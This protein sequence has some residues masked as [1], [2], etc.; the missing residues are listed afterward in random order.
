MRNVRTYGKA[1]YS[2]AV[3]HGGPGAP[4]EM[5][6]VA[7][8]LSAT[9]GV[10]EPI[11]TG[12][13]VEE[14]VEELKD[15]LKDSAVLPVTLIG[16]SWGAMLS[17][18]FAARNPSFMKKLI[19][20]GSG[21]FEDRYAVNI[22]KTRTGR[23]S[24]EERTRLNYLSEALNDPANLEKNADFARLGELLSKADSYDPLF[25]KSEAI[26][27]QYDIYESVWKE[28][29]Q[30]RTSGDLLRMGSRIRCPV[31]AIHGDYDPHSAE[32]VEIPLSGVLNDFRFILLERCGHRPWYERH[33]K[34]RFY[35]ILKSELKTW[36]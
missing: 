5:A 27:C 16:F 26:E 28:A 34:E 31:V 19:L 9:Y 1:P 29:E 18:V 23:L 24:E 4:G 11:Q 33:A 35:A 30:V 13:T 10:L 14:Q 2:I 17:F 8:E 6:P 21:V 12:R 22:M 36:V 3:I 20:V 32:G 7:E 15:I 25:Q